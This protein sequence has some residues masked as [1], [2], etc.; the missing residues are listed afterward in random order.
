MQE[1]HKA[2]HN[3]SLSVIISVHSLVQSRDEKHCLHYTATFE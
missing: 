2:T 1:K 3:G